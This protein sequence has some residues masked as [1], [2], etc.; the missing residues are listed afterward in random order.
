MRRD[1]PLR[2]ASTAVQSGWL[3]RRASDRTWGGMGIGAPCAVCDVIITP[4][5]AEIEVEFAQDGTT[6]GLGKFHAHPRCFA[7][8]D[9]ERTE[10]AP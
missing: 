10:G 1:E 8:W 9:L 6:P 2:K 5:E 7:A 4:A 3:V